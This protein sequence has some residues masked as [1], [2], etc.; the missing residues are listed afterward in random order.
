MWGQSCHLKLGNV[1]VVMWQKSKESR[2]RCRHKR[3]MA[4]LSME[5]PVPVVPER[6]LRNA[7]E[8]VLCW[9]LKIISLKERCPQQKPEIGIQGRTTWPSLQVTKEPEKDKQKESKR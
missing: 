2:Y 4:V 1:S 7:L 6:V 3:Y 9:A 8:G 5:S